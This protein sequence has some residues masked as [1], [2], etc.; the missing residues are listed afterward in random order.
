MVLDLRAIRALCK[1][2]VM[3]VSWPFSLIVT[4]ALGSPQTSERASYT[5][6]PTAEPDV[7]LGLFMM[8][9]PGDFSGSSR[10]VVRSS[11]LMIELELR[12]G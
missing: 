11:H 10:R 2:C 3:G 12:K 6:R 1:F 8:C 4:G 5:G 9:P 7:G